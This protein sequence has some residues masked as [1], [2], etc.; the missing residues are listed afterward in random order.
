MSLGL[1][2]KNPFSGY[3]KLL[4]K[5]AAD[6]DEIRDLVGAMF[7][8][9]DPRDTLRLIYELFLHPGR[10][11][12]SPFLLDPRQSDQ[13]TFDPQSLNRI[14]S[15][16]KLAEE[17]VQS[18]SQ[19]VSEEDF[20]SQDRGRLSELLE[21]DGT[22]S[23]SNAHSYRSFRVVKLGARLRQPISRPRRG[24]PRPSVIV[25]VEFQFLDLRTINGN[26]AFAP[27]EGY[28]VSQHNSIVQRVFGGNLQN[29]AL[30][31]GIR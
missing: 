22:A 6:V 1:G 3:A 9:G 2:K 27:H 10:N 4:H 17:L 11:V 5:P 21:L 31:K 15:D 29:H 24:Q 14:L 13:L 18:L 16:P 30:V 19:G 25:P 8:T 23:G 28:K 26:R 7:V 12:F 20:D